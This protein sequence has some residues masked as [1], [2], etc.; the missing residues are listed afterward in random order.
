[1]RPLL[2]RQIEER[3]CG[4]ESNV[5]FDHSSQCSKRNG[6]H[7]RNST[8]EMQARET[9]DQGNMT[10]TSSGFDWSWLGFGKKDNK[11]GE[12][13]SEDTANPIHRGSTSVSGSG[14]DNRHTEVRRKHRKNKKRADPDRYERRSE[15][16]E[17][18]W[19]EM[20]DSPP[21]ES[22]SAR[23]TGNNRKENLNNK[24]KPK[25]HSNPSGIRLSEFNSSAEYQ[26][27]LQVAVVCCLFVSCRIP[28]L[29]FLSH[30]QI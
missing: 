22:T 25:L 26:G 21:R 4:R 18:G 1:M 27:K 29:P 10:A 5:N 8:A 11:E 7:N 14:W 12:R 30:L 19:T 13:P 15:D 6:H 9:H 17:L 3:Y 23:P 20:T 24:S 28:C 16:I 2:F